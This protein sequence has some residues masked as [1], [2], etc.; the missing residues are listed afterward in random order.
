MLNLSIMQLD[1]DNIDQICEDIIEQQRTGVSS[2]ALFMMQFAPPEGTPPINKA[3]IQCQK[4]D[5][6]RERLDKANAKYGVLVQ[7]TMGHLPLPTNPHPFQN[8][9]SLVDG[10][11]RASTCCP[12][13]EG[14]RAY[15]KEQMR[16]LA[17]HKPSILMIDDDVGLLYRKQ[18][19][20]ACPLHMAEFN[21]RAGTNMTREELYAH[22]Q[23]KTEE[24]RRYTQIYVELIADSLEGAVKAMREGIDEVDPTIQGASSGIHGGR[25]CEFSD[26]T[27]RAIAGKNNNP[28]VRINNG[29][30]TVGGGR[31]FTAGM[32][33]AAIIKEYLKG[34][35][36]TL[37]AEA[38]T[39]P[40]NRYATSATLIHAQLTGSI[41]EGA[42]GA[43]LWITRLKANEPN[44]GKAYRKKL[45]QYHN[46]YE[47]LCEYADELTP[48]GCRIP[49]PTVQDYGFVPAES[50][51]KFG[52]TAKF[53]LCKNSFITHILYI[54]YFHYNTKKRI[55]VL[56]LLI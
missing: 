15:I 32:Y 55:M 37:I 35:D 40:H 31:D 8:V 7:S 21:R 39:C 11:E 1:V 4:Y 36:T 34:T 13:D 27:S 44:A 20:C 2:H 14:F 22:T 46:F 51:M 53:N 3:E 30:Y 38:D 49:L 19:G 56:R 33:R 48:F 42:K 50:G 43:K 17:T 6:F 54:L 29:V 25:F 18:K 12:L 28:I 16:I 9:I 45:A 24:D 41:L 23:G 26:R 5:M 52:L 47:K 10:S